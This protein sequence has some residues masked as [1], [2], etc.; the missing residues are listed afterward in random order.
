MNYPNHSG[1]I[2]RLDPRRDLSPVADLVEDAF[3][4][5]NDPEGS[6]VVSQMRNL[7]SYLATYPFASNFLNAPQGFVWEQG[8][9]IA[10]NI[11]LIPFQ[12]RLKRIFLIANVAV[13]PEYRGRGIAKALTEHAMRF[14]RQWGRSEIWLEVRSDNLPAIHMYQNL[15]FHFFTA[16]TQ[17]EK[18]EKLDPG[19]ALP[20]LDS[21]Q[22]LM[23]R[24]NL[25]DWPLQKSWLEWAYPYA[26]RWY[27]N[28]DLESFAPWA[29]LN[30]FRWGQ[31]NQ[32][33]HFSLKEGHQLRG[34]LTHQISE[35]KTDNLWLALPNDP[36]MGLLARELMRLFL[37]GFWEGKRLFAEFPKDL[38]AAAFIHN[39]FRKMRDLDWMRYF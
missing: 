23:R 35:G 29:W 13:A 24:R 11:S 26:T 38:A 16:I 10:G 22:F 21:A 6:L 31:L 27:Q 15:N 4:L 14:I 39:G 28:A 30:P 33:Q 3:G 7:A 37:Q 17:W 20:S 34:L 25:E 1:Q 36:D 12:R 32:L 2:R 8:G 9:V 18:T 19:P 5:K